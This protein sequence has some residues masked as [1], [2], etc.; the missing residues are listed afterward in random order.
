MFKSIIALLALSSSLP[1]ATDPSSAKFVGAISQKNYVIARE[2]SG[3]IAT[4]NDDAA[5]DPERKTVPFD[6]IIAWTEGCK[7]SPAMSKQH[8]GFYDL[9]WNCGVTIRSGGEKWRTMVRV[10]VIPNGE[11][12][13]LTNLMKPS[14]P[15]RTS[16]PALQRE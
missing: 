4:L 15:D 13:V 2:L 5:S 12:V 16:T 9:W 3:D 1:V 6:A 8:D 7:V 14:F 10:F 11:K